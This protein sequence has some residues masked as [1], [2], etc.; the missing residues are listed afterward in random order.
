M[1]N[2]LQLEMRQQI[3]ITQGKIDFKEFDHLKQQAM[4]L[5][6]H[7]ANVK[8]DEENIKQS[9]KLLAAVN[10]SVKELE[11]RRI[12]IKKV[13]LQPY[14]HFEAQVKEIVGIVKSADQLLRDQVKD[15]E[16]MERQDKQAILEDLWIRRIGLYSFK[17]LFSF[18]DFLKPKHL[19]KTIT[20]DAVEKE[21]VEFL[22]A[23]NK[24]LAVINDLPNADSILSHYTETKDLAAALA[25][26][27]QAQKRLEQVQASKALAAKKVIN[28]DRYDFTVFEE[29]DYKLVCMF[30]ESNKINYET[31]KGDF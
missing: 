25:M 3:M 16:E 21:M 26:E 30:M 11:D 10:K 20:I 17:D 8:V 5:A 6:D 14:D 19:N 12:T 31:C 15:L 1:E 24:D 28:V 9:K 27:S 13:M 4:D 29:K 18:M 23:I 7:I 2:E 22:E